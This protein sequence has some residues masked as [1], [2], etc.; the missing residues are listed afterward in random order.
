[1]RLWRS[2]TLLTKCRTSV[3]RKTGGKSSL[4]ALLFVL[5]RNLQEAPS[6][7]FA[8]RRFR[9]CMPMVALES[10]GAVVSLLLPGGRFGSKASSGC[11][12][13]LGC[14]ST[15]EEENR[16]VWKRL[17]FVRKRQQQIKLQRPD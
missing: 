13:F 9:W 1:M 3:R 16:L 6:I 11:G 4:F 7:T 10:I 5:V 17:S 2:R 15:E 8:G 14:L 12:T